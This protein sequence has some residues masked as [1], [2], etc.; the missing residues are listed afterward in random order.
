MG[1]DLKKKMQ[2]CEQK[3]WKKARKEGCEESWEEAWKRGFERGF[4]RGFKQ[5]I[6]KGIDALI[7][8][9]RKM[10]ISLEE[11]VVQLQE[12]FQLSHRDAM[13]QVKKAMM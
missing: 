5:G 12:E 13:R 10:N 11:I 2:E 1:I 7:S 4:E 8:S 6:Q 3:E 9:L